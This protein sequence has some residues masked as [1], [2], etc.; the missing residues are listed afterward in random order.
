M[1]S[2][3]GSLLHSQVMSSTTTAPMATVSEE[4]RARIVSGMRWTV[5]LSAAAWPFSYGTSVL[6]ARTGP[7]VLGTYAL[8]IVYLG[9]ISTLLYLGGD[10]VLI[11]FLPFLK[12]EQRASFIASYAL[13]TLMALIPW[14]TAATLWPGQLRHVFGDAGSQRLQLA[15]V[16]ASPVYVLFSLIVATLKAGLEIRW[17]QTLLRSVSVGSFLF[18]AV[19]FFANRTVLQRNYP[20]LIPITYLTLAALA[21]VAGC[22]RLVRLNNGLNLRANLH[23]FLPPGF[24]HYTLSTQAT[25]AV[26]FFGQRLDL[27]LVLNLGG[28]P[29]LGKY[30]AIV[31]IGESVKVINRIMLETLLPS[32]TNLLGTSNRTAVAQL[33]S[34]NLRIVFIVAATTTFGGIFL[35]NPLIALLGPAYLPMRPL[36]IVMLLFSGLSAPGAIGGT[37]LSSIGK[38]QYSLVVG[39]GQIAL[40]LGLFLALWPRWGLYGSVVA[41]GVSLLASS[42]ALMAVAKH[43]GPIRFNTIREYTALAALGIPSAW[44]AA[45]YQLGP[46]LGLVGCFGAIGSFLIL[47]GYSPLECK[48]IWRYFVPE[49]RFWSASQRAI[50][51][52][53]DPR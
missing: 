30:M 47:A 16:Y 20:T 39:S 23:F 10:A 51:T 3:G 19:L 37:L 46:G 38:Q 28:L 42:L 50:T 36:F 2:E 22:R 17:A 53:M 6:L 14:L 35:M 9:V 26:G 43:Y 12:Q 5:W 25:S 31:T 15:L 41:A 4:L 48:E 24:W 21:A 44:I 32:L 52:G 34:A 1:G 8:L 7:E 11:R 33:F 45:H 18:Y 40:Y 49:N 13:I 27:I 29:I